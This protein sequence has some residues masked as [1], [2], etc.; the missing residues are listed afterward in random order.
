VPGAGTYAAGR[1]ATDIVHDCVQLTSLA[2]GSLTKA[3]PAILLGYR[4]RSQPEFQPVKHAGLRGQSGAPGS[5]YF[6]DD[7]RI[8]SRGTAVVC[9]KVSSPQ[10]TYLAPLP[11]RHP[12]YSLHR[13]HTG[14]HGEQCRGCVEWAMR[15][16]QGSSPPRQSRIARRSPVRPA[17]HRCKRGLSG[18]KQS[19]TCSTMPMS[20]C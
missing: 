20:T 6:I 15:P 13:L 14:H 3:T 4:S 2:S 17:L 12:L 10:A 5:N 8:G 18:Q 1:N 11:H 16:S 7:P 9:V 19:K